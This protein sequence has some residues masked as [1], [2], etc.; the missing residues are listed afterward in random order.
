MFRADQ[1]RM[2]FDKMLSDNY[3]NVESLNAQRAGYLGLNPFV[4]HQ[5]VNKFQTPYQFP[6]TSVGANPYML[7]DPNSNGYGLKF[8]SEPVYH[9][10][11]ETQSHYGPPQMQSHYG[12]PQMQSKGGKLKGAALSALTLLAFLF[13][14]N[15]LQS[16][17]KDQMDAMNPTVR[18]LILTFNSTLLLI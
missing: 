5:A 6:S 7:N 2:N 14:L 8:A 3:N 16:C 13:F 11:V 12:P 4:N 18:N 15:L 9:S 17:L 10:A 1:A